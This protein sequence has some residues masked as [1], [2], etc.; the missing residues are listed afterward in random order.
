VDI[1]N[2]VLDVESIR[3]LDQG[4]SSLVHE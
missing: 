1:E 4:A 2:L 3:R